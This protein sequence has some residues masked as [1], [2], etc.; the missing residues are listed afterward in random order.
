MNPGRF[1]T[2]L[3]PI[4]PSV[5]GL[6]WEPPDD[7]RAPYLHAGKES[8]VKEASISQQRDALR[9]SVRCVSFLLHLDRCL[10]IDKPYSQG[11]NYAC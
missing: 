2:V 9:R 4:N 5:Q 1:G 3:T 10:P 11:R 8:M 6:D 7:L